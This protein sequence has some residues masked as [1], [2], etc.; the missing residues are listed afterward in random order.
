MFS[1]TGIQ[2]MS[3]SGLH[4]SELGPS[5]SEPMKGIQLSSPSV[6]AMSILRAYQQTSLFFAL[7]AKV[8]IIPLCPSFFFLF[9]LFWALYSDYLRTL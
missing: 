9:F 3:I 2:E 6:P 5:E 1:Q 7:C 4:N 8:T